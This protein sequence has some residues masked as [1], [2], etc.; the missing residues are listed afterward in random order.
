[1]EY[2][3]VAYEIGTLT[4]AA[5]AAADIG[6]AK[7]FQRPVDNEGRSSRRIRF[8][9]DRASKFLVGVNALKETRR[10][11]WHKRWASRMDR[12]I[13]MPTACQKAGKR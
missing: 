6:L 7:S 5:R 8:E 3:H 9:A 4:G 1:M 12:S 10:T 13:Y 11:G 2:K